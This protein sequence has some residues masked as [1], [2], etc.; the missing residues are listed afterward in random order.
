M[1]LEAQASNT[2]PPAPVFGVY[3]Q[4]PPE[5]QGEIMWMDRSS[6]E[7]IQNTIN[8]IITQQNNISQIYIPQITNAPPRYKQLPIAQTRLS[9]LQQDQQT[10]EQALQKARDILAKQQAVQNA[11]QLLTENPDLAKQTGFNLSQICNQ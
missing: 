3:S 6:M 5:V 8:D 2:P 4:V 9:A 11:F 1:N 10:L 7:A